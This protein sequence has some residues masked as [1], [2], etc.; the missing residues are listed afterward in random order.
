MNSKI[1]LAE[2]DSSYQEPAAK[3][4]NSNLGARFG[5][6][7]ESMNPDL[8]NIVKS[9]RDGLFLVA[10]DGE[11]VVGTGA[12][13]IAKEGIGQIVRMHTAPEYRRRGIATMILNAL[14]NWAVTN[15][16]GSLVLETEMHWDDAVGFYTRSGYSELERN[17]VDIQFG[18]S[19]DLS[20]G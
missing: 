7:D 20:G 19:L 18:K 17:E 1:R 8:F 12:L 6:V 4:I 9:Y 10:I 5:F 3:L 11:L 14:E 16:L 13:T 2:I 15:R